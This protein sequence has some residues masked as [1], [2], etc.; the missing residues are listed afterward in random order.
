MSTSLEKAR[1]ETAHYLSHNGEWGDREE[2]AN[3]V[4]YIVDAAME[5]IDERTNRALK[6]AGGLAASLTMRDYFA[7]QAMQGW[8]AT[9]PDEQRF[10]EVNGDLVASNAYR[11]ADAML[12]AREAT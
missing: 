2:A 9:Y 5:A 4:D 7:A 8:L 10:D 1:E 12:K 3:C 6:V 11:I